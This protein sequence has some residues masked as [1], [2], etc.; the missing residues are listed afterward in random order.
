MAKDPVLSWQ[1]ANPAQTRVSRFDDE[2]LV[3]NPLSWETHLVGFPALRLIEALA[4]GPKREAELV[5]EI[6]DD[7]DG[8]ASDLEGVR[9]ETRTLLVELESLGLVSSRREMP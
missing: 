9:T 2:A 6:A 8:A 5:A 7:D 4:N 1:L 3:F